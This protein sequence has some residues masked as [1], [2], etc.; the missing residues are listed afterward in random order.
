MQRHALN[1]FVFICISLASSVA[2]G[3][4]NGL[5]AIG[6]SKWPIAD[7]NALAEMYV[8]VGGDLEI[9]IMPK[10]FNPAR[11]YE[12]I[13]IFI[14]NVLPRLDGR[15]RIVAYMYFH[16]YYQT[17]CFT[18]SRFDWRAFADPRSKFRLDYLERVTEM[19]T[20]IKKLWPWIIQNRL[21]DKI[22]FECCP[23][24]EDYLE[25]EGATN[26]DYQNLVL[27]IEERQVN[28]DKVPVTI[29][30]L[31]CPNN[32]RKDQ[33]SLP[34]IRLERHGKFRDV[35]GWLE[36]GDSYSNDG[37]VVTEEQFKADQKKALSAGIHTAWWEQAFNGDYTSAKP[38][39]RK[40]A[41]SFATDIALKQ[42]V[43]T[44]LKARE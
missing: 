34:G 15:L 21:Q 40:V 43:L 11:P 22:I 36:P 23:F 25:I 20:W 13:D 44:I 3:A 26:A 7:V 16:D 1:F 24:L 19:N 37:T 6:F 39:A 29:I 41:P 2:H 17:A 33:R 10:E 4:F 5:Q 27:A 31:R 28:I 42:R 9:R 14:R 12:N 32:R 8:S 18:E 35:S 38:C 30:E